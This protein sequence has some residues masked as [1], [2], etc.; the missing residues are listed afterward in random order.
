MA[1]PYLLIGLMFA[2][3]RDNCRGE[4]TSTVFLCRLCLNVNGA[5]RVK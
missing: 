2:T 3:N 5:T 1:M 4:R